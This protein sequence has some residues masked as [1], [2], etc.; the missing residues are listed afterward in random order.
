MW[1]RL[2]PATPR[3]S[4][5]VLGAESVLV[6]VD[7]AHVAGM[8]VM[9]VVRVRV[10]RVVVRVWVSVWVACVRVAGMWV[11]SAHGMT[12][13]VFQGHSIAIHTV[14]VVPPIIAN[15]LIKPLY[16]IC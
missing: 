3:C 5:P 4:V 1:C 6:G 15:K 10:M 7:V 13:G 9:V 11:A 16:L 12:E 14:T 2:L 8:M